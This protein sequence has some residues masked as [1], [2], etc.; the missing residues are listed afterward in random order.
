M[1]ECDEQRID[2]Y[3]WQETHSY[4]PGDSEN[5]YRPSFLKPSDKGLAKKV[6]TT[7]EVCDEDNF[8]DDDTVML[9][10]IA[11]SIASMV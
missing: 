4:H 9:A 11:S 5:P 10:V 7:D 6:L 3:H 2:E 1:D 8:D